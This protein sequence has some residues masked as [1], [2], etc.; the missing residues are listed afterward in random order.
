MQYLYTADHFAYF[1][2]TQSY[3]Q[4]P[5]NEDLLVSEAVP[6]GERRLRRAVHD[7][8]SGRSCRS[9][10]KRKSWRPIPAFAGH[11]QG[12]Q[13]GHDRDGCG[14]PVPLFIERGEVTGRYATNGYLSE[15]RTRTSFAT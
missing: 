10:S 9:S 11:G 6:E 5:V 4:H 2:D 12:Y 1:M 8:R 13:A 14:R 3:E 15:C 7:G